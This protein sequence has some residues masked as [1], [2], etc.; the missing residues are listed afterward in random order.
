ML[1]GF[2]A[3]ALRYIFAVVLISRSIEAQA[4]VAV[5]KTLLKAGI[6]ELAT[7]ARVSVF[8]D[9]KLIPYCPPVLHKI[10]INNF[11]YNTYFY[12]NLIVCGGC[13]IACHTREAAHNEYKQANFT[14]Y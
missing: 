8:D 10:I 13:T 1:H 5:P 2:V 3:L 14:V 4:Q 7:P 11:M 9:V 6:N 12:H